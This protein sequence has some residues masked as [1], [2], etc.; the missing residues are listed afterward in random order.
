[1]RTY[2]RTSTGYG[3]TDED[4]AEIPESWTVITQDEYD[5]LVAADQQA[6]E[7]AANAEI[8]AANARWTTV[9]DDLIRIGASDEA[10]VLLANVV[11]FPPA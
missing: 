10:A 8:A 9:H 6:A 1:V 11:G 3:Y 5:A 7:D 4:L 2:Y